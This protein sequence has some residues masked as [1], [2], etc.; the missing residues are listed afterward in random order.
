MTQHTNLRTGGQILV[1]QLEIHGVDMAFGVPGESYL[2][3]LD[4][5]YDSEIRYVVCRQEAGATMMAE[6]YGKLTGKP[7]IAMVTRGPG[8]TNGCHGVHIARQDSTPLILLIGQVARA[9]RGR[10]AFQEIDYRQMFAGIAKWVCEIDDPARIPELVARAFHTATSGRPGP[11]VIALPEDMLTEPA[12]CADARALSSGPGPSRGR[13]HGA[14]ARAPVRRPAAVRDPRRRRLE[15]QGLRRHRSA[16]PTASICRSAS[17]SGART[18]STTRTAATP[19]TSASRWRRRS[20]TACA[21]RTS[22]SWSGPAWARPR[23][24]ATA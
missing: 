21:T 3:L 22:C 17:P 1:D 14:P 20:A 15:R 4:A 5:L 10:E 23:A 8:A 16:S 12:A 13:G 11:V 9:M 18:T 6:A 7:G 19:A 24:A 2:A